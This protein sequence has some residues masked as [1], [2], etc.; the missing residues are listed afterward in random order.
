MA[1][2]VTTSSGVVS[3]W[4]STVTSASLSRAGPNGARRV[5]QASLLVQKV[6][7][8]SPSLSRQLNTPFCR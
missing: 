5:I 8:Q 6:N 1:I 2:T 4:K 3:A 7:S